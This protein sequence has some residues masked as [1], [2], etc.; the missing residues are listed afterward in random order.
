MH[1]TFTAS[2]EIRIYP[3]SS[4]S[5]SCIHEAVTAS[6]FPAEAGHTDLFDFGCFHDWMKLDLFYLAGKTCVGEQVLSHILLLFCFNA[7]SY[8][9]R[10]IPDVLLEDICGPD[11]I[12]L[13]VFDGCW[14]I[15]LGLV[16]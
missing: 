16:T 5:L 2:I 8:S 12:I 15:S 11:H 9:K 4:K 6:C 3:L 7:A 14:L 1:K 13:G 10:Q